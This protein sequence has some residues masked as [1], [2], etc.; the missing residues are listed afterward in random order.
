M[1]E[2]ERERETYYSLILWGLRV[3]IITGWSTEEPAWG[4][5]GRP[6][7]HGVIHSVTS[8]LTPRLI[9]S[10][11]NHQ[12][13]PNRGPSNWSQ[14]VLRAARARTHTS[15]L[16]HRPTDRRFFLLLLLLYAFRIER[17]WNNNKIEAYRRRRWRERQAVTAEAAT[18]DDPCRIGRRYWKTSS[19]LAAVSV[20]QLFVSSAEK[21]WLG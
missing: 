18:I 9:P 5:V 20:G 2:W 3:C 17:T 14:A 4:V 13:P 11:I 10:I 16:S 19:S 6:E 1:R 21:W 12:T 15:Y 8:L 7:A